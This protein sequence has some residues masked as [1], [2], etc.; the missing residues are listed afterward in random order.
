MPL[1]LCPVF[2][3]TPLL[4]WQCLNNGLVLQ[5][6][7]W[8]SKKFCTAGL[9]VTPKCMC[10]GGAV[11]SLGHILFHCSVVQLLWKT[12]WSLRGLHPGQFHLEQCCATAE[13]KWTLCVLVFIWHYESHDLDDATKG[14][15]WGGGC[16]K[17]ILLVPQYLTVISA[18]IRLLGCHY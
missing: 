13:N 8:V 6:S 12:D 4:Q 2:P 7:L 14:I 9:A 16:M 17:I 10:Y 11:E 3:I 1:G 15:L 5:K 18:M